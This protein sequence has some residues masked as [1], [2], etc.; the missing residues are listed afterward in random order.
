VGIDLSNHVKN[1]FANSFLLSLYFITL[2]LFEVICIIVNI[3]DIPNSPPL[4]CY[5]C[6]NPWKIYYL[7]IASKPRLGLYN[8][9]KSHWVWLVA[10]KLILDIFKEK[11]S[12]P[13]FVIHHP[14]RFNVH[15]LK[16][17]IRLYCQAQ[18][19]NQCLR[20]W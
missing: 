7:I 4:K 15:N 20:F 8:P 18:V 2:N 13:K 3:S 10:F 19:S 16:M 12:K 17:R 11:G 6:L 9:I 14:L 5:S 1:E